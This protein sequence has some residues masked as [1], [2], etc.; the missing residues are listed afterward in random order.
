RDPTTNSYI[1]SGMV[2]SQETDTLVSAAGKHIVVASTTQYL[3]PA[4]TLGTTP[5]V[6]DTV[7]ST[8]TIKEGGV[9]RSNQTTTTVRGTQYGELQ[10][11]AT[12][13][14]DGAV[15]TTSYGYQLTA[16]A[17]WPPMLRTSITDTYVKDGIGMASRTINETRDVNT[18]LLQVR[19][20]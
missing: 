14:P 18:G 3:N 7:V 20:R 10:R 1:F 11:V 12:E 9:V 4:G 5:L 6:Y 2:L 15:A 19:T 16:T 8:E 17:L 13:T